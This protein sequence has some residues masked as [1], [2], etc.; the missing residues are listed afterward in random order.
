[1]L[2]FFKAWQSTRPDSIML[3]VTTEPKELILTEAA[4]QGIDPAA[5]RIVSASR[6]E[7]PVYIS[8][9]DYGLFFLKHAFSK[10][11]SSPVKQG[12][13]MAMGIPVICNAGVGD[14]DR[15]VQQ[16][17]AGILVHEYTPAGYQDAIARLDSTL[18]DPALIR[19]GSIDYFDLQKGIESYARIYER[20]T[21]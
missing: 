1:M 16:Y 20:L 10:K 7:V 19:E 4:N 3:F 2:Q 11:A 15:I 6:V 21:A 13:L 14:S 8:M 5:I 17:S 18:F 12:E 9:M